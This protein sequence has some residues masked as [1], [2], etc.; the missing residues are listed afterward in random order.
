MQVYEQPLLFA[1][2]SGSVWVDI[3]AASSPDLGPR[4]GFSAWPNELGKV[5]DVEAM[6]TKCGV[7]VLQKKQ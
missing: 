4:W 3:L 1:S 7:A 6:K 2:V 5:E